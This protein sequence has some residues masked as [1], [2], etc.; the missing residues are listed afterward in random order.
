MKFH[1][2]ELSEEKM[3]NFCRHRKISELAFFGSVLRDDF[4]PDSDIDVLVTFVPDCGYS[5]LD[6]A[7]IKQELGT[8]LG[9]EIDLVEK[10][11]LQNPFRKHAILNNMEIVY[12]A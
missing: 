2:I 7:E 10:D 4:R 8:I 12:A 1:R 9:H 3:A 5:L 11:S 6:L